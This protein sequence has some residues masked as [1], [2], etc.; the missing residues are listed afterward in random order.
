MKER[1]YR[2]NLLDSV[3]TVFRLAYTTN[4]YF[5]NES[6]CLTL[7]FGSSFVRRLSRPV[8][9]VPEVSGFPNARKNISIHKKRDGSMVDVINDR[10]GLV[11]STAI[12]FSI[13]C[14]SVRYRFTEVIEF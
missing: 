2:P 10:K 13:L 4:I 11:Y 14:F 1:N 3:V 6:M 9:P 5:Q 12:N 7:E 8:V